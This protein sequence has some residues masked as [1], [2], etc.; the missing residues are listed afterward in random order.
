MGTRL[1]QYLSV[2]IISTSTEWVIILLFQWK[3]QTG[4]QEK[5]MEVKFLELSSKRSNF[6]LQE[7]MQSP[8]KRKERGTE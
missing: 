2:S 4:T 8:W 3:L 5:K 1:K 7:W 6:K